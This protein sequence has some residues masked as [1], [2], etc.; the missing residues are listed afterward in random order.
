MEA[1][2]LLTVCV[3]AYC[4]VPPEDLGDTIF[5]SSGG[6]LQFAE[7]AVATESELRRADFRS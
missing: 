7:D 2:E 4:I 5:Q 6:N 3:E 1:I